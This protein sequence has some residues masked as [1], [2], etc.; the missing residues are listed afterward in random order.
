MSFSD[1]MSSARGPGVIGTL[2]AMAVMAIF[3]MF[4]V[5]AFDDRFQGGN[6]SIESVIRQQA[7]E[8][9]QYHFGIAEG[10]KTLVQIT[11]MVAATKELTR[12]KNEN[13]A[14]QRCVIT[15]GK[16]IESGK[17]EIICKNEAFEAYKD[18]YRNHV[19]SKAKGET[20]ENLETQ[21]GTIY[22]NVNIREVTAIGIQIRHEE[23]QKRIP[24]EELPEAM[25]DYYQFDT[26]QKATA[27]TKE[28]A[29]WNEHEA[30]AITASDNQSVEQSKKSGGDLKDKMIRARALKESRVHSL[31][32]EIRSLEAAIHSEG[33]KGISRAP[34]M[35]EKLTAKQSELS[36]LRTDLA[37]MRAA[38]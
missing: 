12:L 35:R 20:L 3:V 18:Q 33:L 31:G 29:T 2:M 13:E 17:I 24:F 37:R 1:M 22:K 21:S 36:A 14:L 10:Q 30:A 4:F 38:Q 28:Q 34:E 23:G 16:S 27:L 5:F 8:I 32:E 25:K 6:Q 26:K 19:R 7:Q 11:V 15:L 9:D